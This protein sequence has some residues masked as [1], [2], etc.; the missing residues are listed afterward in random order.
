MRKIIFAS[1][2]VLMLLPSPHCWAF[3]TASPRPKNTPNSARLPWGVPEPVRCTR[4]VE[5]TAARQTS[6]RST[7]NSEEPE[8][9]YPERQNFDNY[10]LGPYS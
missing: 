4:G 6:G 2:A 8:I 3:T 1:C 7:M 9:V 5:G 10:L